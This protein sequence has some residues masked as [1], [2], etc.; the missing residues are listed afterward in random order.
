MMTLS[1]LRGV[2]LAELVCHVSYF[3]ADAYARWANARLPTEAERA[4]AARNVAAEGNF[5]ETCALQLAIAL[6][7]LPKSNCC[8]RQP[9]WLWP[10]LI[11]KYFRPVK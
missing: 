11:E 4:V 10:I 8:A 1:D 6:S 5:V 7:I 2:D 3:E 9:L